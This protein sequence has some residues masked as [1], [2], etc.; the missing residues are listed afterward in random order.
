MRHSDS[1]LRIGIGHLRAEVSPKV[2]SLKEMSMVGSSMN[3]DGFVYFW[4]LD[5]ANK[6]FR[7]LGWRLTV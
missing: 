4:Y 1:S 2:S 3:F 6:L 7:F 5:K